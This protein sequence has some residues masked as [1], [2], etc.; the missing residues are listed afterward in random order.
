[1]WRRWRVFLCC[2]LVLSSVWVIANL[3]RDGG[4]L[5]GVH[6]VGRGRVLVLWQAAVV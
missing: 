3:P 4:S 1:M 5:K 6:G 2:A